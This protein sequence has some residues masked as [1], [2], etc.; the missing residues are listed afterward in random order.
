LLALG[1]AF[2]VVSIIHLIF[3][4]QKQLPFFTHVYRLPR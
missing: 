1:S 2:C 4:A 3:C